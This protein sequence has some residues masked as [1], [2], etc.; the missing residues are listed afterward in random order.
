MPEPKYRLAMPPQGRDHDVVEWLKKHGKGYQTRI[1][2]ILHSYNEGPIRRAPVGAVPGS[3]V[4]TGQH[5][6][7]SPCYKIAQFRLTPF[8]KA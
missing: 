5:I 2:A 4:K 8:P 7:V 1:N 3:R 6:S